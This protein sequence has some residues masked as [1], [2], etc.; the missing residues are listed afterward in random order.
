MADSGLGSFLPSETA[1]KDPNRF[2]D[3]LRAE[4]S[5]R[6]SYLSSMD[7]Y[8]AQLNEA[9]RQFDLTLGFKQE[10]LEAEKVWRTEDIAVKREGIA[11][12]V[13]WRGEALEAEVA[14]RGED[15]AVRREGLDVERERI[16]AE[17]ERWK[18]ELSA[19]RSY[20]SEETG[21]KREQLAFEREKEET[22]QENFDWMK[23]FMAMQGRMDYDPRSGALKQPSTP[24]FGADWSQEVRDSFGAY[25]TPKEEPAGYDIWEY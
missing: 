4:G 22:S 9:T 18:S 16:G 21:V 7:Q 5:K 14:W 11:A 12:E 17:S 1:Y 2:K 20:R 13:D 15:I 6:A 8:Y 10:E 25:H 24:T 23:P 19:L 3:V